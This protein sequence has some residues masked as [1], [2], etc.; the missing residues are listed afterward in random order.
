MGFE[1]PPALV[2]LTGALLIAISPGKLYKSLSLLVP[3]LTLVAVWLF[4]AGVQVE[5]AGPWLGYEL[6]FAKLNG[7]TRA[8]ATV[9]ALM[10]LAGALYAW[11]QDRRVELSAAMI[12]AGSAIGVTFAGDLIT[13]FVFWELMAIGSTIVIWSA[14]SEAARKA[15]L[16]YAYVHLLGGAVL[17]AGLAL[18]VEQTGSIALPT[19]TM[20]L[21]LDDPVRMTLQGQ[22]WLLPRLQGPAAWLILIGVLV[23]AGAPPFGAWLPDAYP[24]SSPSGMVFLSAFTT[25]TAVYVLIVLFAGCELLIWVGC[26]MALF[27]IVYGLLQNDLRGILAYSLINQVGFMVCGVGLGTGLALNGATA[28]AFAHIIY[29][30]LLLM[31]AGSVLLMTGKRNCTDLGGLYKAMPVTMW[32]GIVGALSISAMPLTSGFTTKSMI[33]DAAAIPE[34]WALVREVGGRQ[35]W[36]TMFDP[37]LA[38]FLLVAASAGVFLDT[39]L[40]FPWFV[41]FQKRAPANDDRK[42]DPPANMKLAMALFAGL[43]LLLGVYPQPLY[44]LLPFQAGGGPLYA[45]YDYGHVIHQLQL[46]LFS[47]LA[48]FLLLDMLKR[49][50]T[51]ALDIDWVYRRAVPALWRWIVHPLLLAAQPFHQAIVGLP[52]YAATTLGRSKAGQR[53]WSVGTTV[54]ICTAVLALFLLLHY[55]EQQ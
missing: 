23:N 49:T 36:A 44:A 16:R 39:G 19:M 30:A 31:S 43:C 28:H 38:W 33:L 17:M 26:L 27:G 55:F 48:F 15:G 42:L 41:F 37:S 32:C 11:N 10:A 18:H 45:A 51:I 20:G 2:M 35:L 52:G 7:P 3:A 54:L 8:F 9:F 29:K 13:M 14:G 53:T 24:E 12:Y 21:E 46:L 4:P 47:G 5:A 22:P 1:F 50:E 40:K 25:K 34:N 6:I